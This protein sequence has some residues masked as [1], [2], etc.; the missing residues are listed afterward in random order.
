MNGILALAKTITYRGTVFRY[1]AVAELVEVVHP[2][3]INLRPE[4]N[5]V[6]DIKAHC[7]REVRLEMVGALKEAVTRAA[8]RKDVAVGLWVIEFEIDGTNSSLEF[9]YNPFGAD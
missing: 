1:P 4:E 5:V 3:G 6:R 2:S 9:G 8:S 7:C